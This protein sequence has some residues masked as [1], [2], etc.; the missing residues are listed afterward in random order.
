[1]IKDEKSLTG[2]QQLAVLMQAQ[3]TGQQVAISGG[4]T[5]SRWSDGEDINELS[6][7]IKQ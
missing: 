1:M 5:C 3:A 2:K 6:I 4:N 7:V